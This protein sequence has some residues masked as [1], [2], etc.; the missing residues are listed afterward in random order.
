MS[1]INFK[2]VKLEQQL[3]PNIVVDK[4][5]DVVKYG[6]DNMF[7]QQLLDLS[8]QS[9]LHTAILDKKTK[10]VVGE[11]FNYTGG[12]NKKTEDFIKQVNPYENMNDL[13]MKCGTDLEIFGGF[14]LQVIWT[15]DKKSIAE[16]YHSPFQNL[17]SG[18]VNEKNQIEEYFY[19]DDWKRYTRYNDTTAIK[20]FNIEVD[21]NGPQLMYAKKYSATNM[22][23]PL[24]SYVGGLNDI[25]TL[26]E[27]SVFHNACISNN[28]QP[29]IMI[30]FRGPRPSEDAQDA[31]MKALSE[32]YQGAK[33]AGTPSVFFLDDD[34]QEPMIKPTQTNNL[35]KQYDT[36]TKAVKES[37]IM[38][39]SI[40]PVSA[41]LLVGG[42]LG[43]GKEIVEADEIFYNG[44][45][46]HE[47]AFLL[48]YFN[49]IMDINGMKEL[50]IINTKQLD[51][52]LSK[53]ILTRNELREKY[54][55]EALEDG[56]NDENEV[57]VE[58]EP[59]TIK[60]EKIID[61]NGE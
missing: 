3:S 30:V 42:S 18:K 5:S 26:Y 50:S 19:Y 54:G 57:V 29:G 61:T 43:G 37:V 2:F 60:P 27:I 32:K 13:L 48:R 39:H 31:I 40:H 12:N 9:S 10:M 53:E 14:G 24:P 35:D 11:G 8:V 4:R 46:K 6:T 21:K 41:G 52:E 59:T 47:Q 45:I 7:P 25:N 23:Y 36:L 38:A 15:R 55:Y 51:V 22:Y 17:R 49:K 56:T 44:Y 20:S 34:Q 58:D 33:N 28:F 1:K 16:L